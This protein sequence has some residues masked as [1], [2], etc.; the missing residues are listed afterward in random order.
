MFN[1]ASYI[2][3]INFTIYRLKCTSRCR[4]VI[5]GT[6]RL[7]V[8]LKMYTDLS[9]HYLQGM[10]VLKNDFKIW[11]VWRKIPYENSYF[12]KLSSL[13]NSEYEDPCIFWGQRVHDQCQGSQDDIYIMVCILFIFWLD[14]NSLRHVRNL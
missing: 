4:L 1:L 11:A 10:I 2:R 8:D 12:S 13:V 9:T 6:D 14:K 7:L 3:H 5:P